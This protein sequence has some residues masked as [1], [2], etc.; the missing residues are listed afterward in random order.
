MENKTKPAAE[1]SSPSKQLAALADRWAVVNLLPCTI[2]IDLP[3]SV[4]IGDLLDLEVGSVVNS[5]HSPSA[6]VPVWVNGIVI[7]LAEFDLSGR[8]LA[9]RIT[10]VC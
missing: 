1:T 3:T 2:S 4:T 10:E 9:V 7:G 5:H 6:P 8:H